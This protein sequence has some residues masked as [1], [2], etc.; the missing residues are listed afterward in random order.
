MLIDP[1]SV[2]TLPGTVDIRRSGE[3]SQP[4]VVTGP[5]R[6]VTGVRVTEICQS[7]NVAAVTCECR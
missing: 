7:C 3:M 6:G 4:S 2:E 1:E 5:L